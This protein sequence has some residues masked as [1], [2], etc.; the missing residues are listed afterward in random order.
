VQQRGSKWYE[1]K[2]RQH[3]K[4]G[5]RAGALILSCRLARGSIHFETAGINSR[6]M[7]VLV[8]ANYPRT[9][10]SAKYL[11][12]RACRVYQLEVSAVSFVGVARR[13]LKKTK[14]SLVCGGVVNAVT[15]GFT[16]PGHCNDIAPYVTRGLVET[17]KDGRVG[18][19][20]SFTQLAWTH[21][22]LVCRTACAPSSCFDKTMS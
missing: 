10:K 21:Q 15:E 16:D 3:H 12:L 22:L 4:S 14:V 2:K 11:S 20:D 7:Q 19:E 8:Q 13:I 1:S 17:S 5:S 18:L 6:Q 9:A